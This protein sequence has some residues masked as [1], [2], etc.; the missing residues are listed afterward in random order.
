MTPKQAA[1]VQQY[2]VD[3]N[4]AQAAIRAGYSAKTAAAIG[5]ENLK[6]PEI[7]AVITEQRRK[8]AARADFTVDE[9]MDLLATIRDKAIAEGKYSAAVAAEIARGKVAGFYVDRIEMNAKVLG[10]VNYQANLPRRGS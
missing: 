8:I 2:L 4:A 1:F 6:K 5:Y 10:T 3:L 9:H 7:A